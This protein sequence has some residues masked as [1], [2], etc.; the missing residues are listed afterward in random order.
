MYDTLIL[1]NNNMTT[2]SKD[3]LREALKQ[4]LKDV[5]RNGDKI[6]E[7]SIVIRLLSRR[8]RELEESS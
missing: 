2:E 8:V 5:A 7:Q 1:N 3:E 6:K 4:A